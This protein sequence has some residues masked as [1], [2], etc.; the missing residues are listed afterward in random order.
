VCEQEDHIE[1]IRRTD[2]TRTHIEACYRNDVEIRWE[3]VI[4]DEPI[5]YL[6]ATDC[7]KREG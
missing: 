7:M 3:P 1:G 4:Y 6:R 5:L 2:V